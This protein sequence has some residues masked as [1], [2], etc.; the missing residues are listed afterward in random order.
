MPVSADNFK[1]N[2]NQNLWGLVIG[3][4]S[5]GASE[6]YELRTLYYFSIIISVIMTVSILFTTY[7]YTKSYMSRKYDN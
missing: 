7:A 3:S 1:I 4:V 2:L 6:Y 5:L